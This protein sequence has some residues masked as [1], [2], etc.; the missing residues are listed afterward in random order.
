MSFRI[1]T[2]AVLAFC[3]VVVA[4]VPDS[5]ES[6]EWRRLDVEAVDR[7]DKSP[8]LPAFGL[9]TRI[10]IA[11]T[12]AQFEETFEFARAAA[13]TLVPS[14]AQLPPIDFDTEIVVLAH[15][16]TDSC[17][18]V[19]NGVLVSGDRV[20]VDVATAIVSDEIV[21]L[22]IGVPHTFFVAIERSSL[23]QGPFT[24]VGSTGLTNRDGEPAELRIEEDLQTPGGAANEPLF[25]MARRPMLPLDPRL[26][27]G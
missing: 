19:F 3:I 23:P 18:A 12:P 26:G 7:G 6:A 24:L 25:A 13:D 15:T 10:E 14:N 21:C 1:V 9:G 16:M 5:A 8:Q 22:S 27:G 20:L 4:C 2:P 11:T 17:G